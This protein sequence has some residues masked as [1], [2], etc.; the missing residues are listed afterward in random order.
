MISTAQAK[1]WLDRYFSGESTLEEEA[2]L[3]KY[4]SQDECAEELLPYQ[5]LFVYYKQAQQE[6]ASADFNQRLAHPPQQGLRI[7]W[8]RWSIA[9][10]IALLL[11]LAA[12]VWQ[13]NNEVKPIA[14]SS[15]DWSKYEL[16]DPVQALQVAHSAL[17]RTSEALHQ[18]TKMATEEVQQVKNIIPNLK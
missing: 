17:K 18:S 3:R 7:R 10:T 2:G 5:Q 1:L 14:Q 9:A 13:S 4:F 6:V 15:I 11:G 8:Q 16:K 12:W